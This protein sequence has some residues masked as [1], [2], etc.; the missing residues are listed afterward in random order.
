M[1][2][3]LVFE[4]SRP[5]RFGY[6]FPPSDVP[7]SSALP[8]HLARQ[9]APIL[10]ELSEL[11]VVRH[12]SHLAKMAFGVDH[13]PYPLGSCTMKYNPKLHNHVAALEGFS[14]LH[15]LQDGETTQGALALLYDLTSS[16]AAITGMDWGTMQ[17][18][19]GAHGEYTGLKIIRAYHLQRGDTGRTKV[20]VPVSAHGTNPASAALNGFSIVEVPADS[21][22]LVDIR[23]LEDLLD[24]SIAGIMLTNPN[25]LGLFEQDI[26][27]IADMVH[28]CGGLLYYDG[29]NLNAIMGM[30]RPGDMGFDVVHLNLHKTFSTPHGGGGP[31]AGPVLVG[32]KLV[33]FL[34][35]PNIVKTAT[36]FAWDWESENSIGKVSGFWGNF[37]VLVKAYA[38][39]LTMGKEGLRAASQHA[40]LNANYMLSLLSE[41]FKAPYGTTCMHEFVLSLQDYKE[42]YG[43]SALDLAKAMLDHGYHPPTM[44]FPLIVHEA[45][46]F[47]PTETE[48]IE[49]LEAMVET[50]LELADL[51]KTKSKELKEAPRT[52]EVRRLD[53]IRAAKFPVLRW[54]EKEK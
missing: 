26:K 7:I 48:A 3:A 9:N 14:A 1:S 12:Y 45:L 49:D 18:S 17:P 37:L 50:L 42:A 22:G 25:T 8:A 34:P 28:D 6:T 19:A 54:R 30:A 32:E 31:G 20:I 47:E 2:K 23:A 11:G 51:A 29:A 33:P 41:K 36:G 4:L 5:G 16:L 38:Y 24:D 44:Y 53:E 27:P 40:V 15:P 52:T 13:G 21:R 39:I 46:M 43:V 10:P 35:K